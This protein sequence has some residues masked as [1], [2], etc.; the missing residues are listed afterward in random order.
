M[1]AGPAFLAAIFALTRVA[2]VRMNRMLRLT[3]PGLNAAAAYGRVHAI[4]TILPA[5]GA[6]FVWIG[7]P[8]VLTIADDRVVLDGTDREDWTVTHVSIGE[9][10]RPGR[11]SGINLCTPDG[12]RRISFAPAGDPTV[13]LRYVL[14]ARIS[15]AIRRALEHGQDS[16]HA[17]LTE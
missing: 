1:T 16:P 5:D 17:P 10:Q 12:L 6:R 11:R 2:T 9:R 14:D 8:G 7:Q 4:V 3:L 15:P 13:N